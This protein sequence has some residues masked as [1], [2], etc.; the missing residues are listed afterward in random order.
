MLALKKYYLD[1]NAERMSLISCSS[2]LCKM[3]SIYVGP[4][5]VMIN[6]IRQYI[7]SCLTW[8]KE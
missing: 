8:F 2:P 5:T 7:H 3:Y 6:K 1:K 4:F